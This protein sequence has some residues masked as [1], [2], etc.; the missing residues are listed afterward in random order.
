[1]N[2]SAPT[3]A[4]Q[5]S[6]LGY[7]T[8]I[9]GKW[10]L[11]FCKQDYLPTERGFDHHFGFWS[12]AED[13]F[14]HLTGNAYDF[15]K[16][17]DVFPSAKGKYSTALFQNE[18]VDII[19][20]HNQS[21]PLFLYLPFQ[22]PHI[23]L[24]VPL[25]FN[26]YK[27]KISNIDRATYLGMVTAMDF[28]V[29]R[30]IKALEKQNMISNTLIIFMSDNGGMP[31]SGNNWPLRGGKHT[32][33]EGGTRVPAFISGLGLKPRTESGIFH[34]SDW[35]PTILGAVDPHAFYKD[36]DGVNHWESL[37][38]P[39]IPWARKTMIYNIGE[40]TEKNHV[41]VAAIRVE[42]WKYVWR[43]VGHWKGWYLPAER[44]LGNESQHWKDFHFNEFR[45]GWE[46]NKDPHKPVGN[47]LFD[48]STDPFEK[49][50]L[51]SKYPELVKELQ[52][53]LKVSMKT[54]VGRDKNNV[55][56]PKV[57]HGVWHTG[58]CKSNVKET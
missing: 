7:T 57:K 5:L 2:A 20:Q 47:L 44:R 17:M 55:V 16:N 34:I 18:A 14:T 25:R 36:V 10:H 15:R 42:N 46:A 23:P 50:N 37:I 49:V 29:G 39:R 3:I 43:E 32:L 33:F 40:V 13:Y 27:K 31:K 24:E 19:K 51:A 1:M 53:K 12:G 54:T 48:L 9:V 45:R 30:I 6:R 35:Y 28:A 4:E 58:W 26:I 52:D 56:G 22:S 21:N 38:N 41:P 11:G 8:H